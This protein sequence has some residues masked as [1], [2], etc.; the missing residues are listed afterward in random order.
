MEKFKKA[1][2]I[3]LAVIVIS[4]AVFAVASNVTPTVAKA[5]E[6]DPC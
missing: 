5:C 1:M 3:I 4:G 6:Q 2:R